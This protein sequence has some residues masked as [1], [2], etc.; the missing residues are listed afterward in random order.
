LDQDQVMVF[1]PVFL[2]NSCMINSIKE[3]LW[4]QFGASI[5]MLSNAIEQWPEDAFNINKRIFYL[6]YHTLVFLD[7][8]LTLPPKDFKSPL[9][10]TVKEEK[11]YEAVDDVVP[12]RFY[13]KAELLQYL[14]HS[15]DKCFK[16]IDS[17]TE[18]KLKER[19]V[20]EEEGGKNFPIFEIL[21][22]NMRHVQHHAAQLNLLLRQSNLKAPR[23]VRQAQ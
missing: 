3:N 23:W 14:K 19:F 7:Y 9:P 8:Y 17:L 2:A 12:D 21:L 10:F 15:H 16:L 13:S 22:Y 20:E 18:E 1:T 11:P 6:S 5:D 4:K